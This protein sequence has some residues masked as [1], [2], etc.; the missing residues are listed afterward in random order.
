M[1][2]FVHKHKLFAQAILGLIILTFAFFGVESYFRSSD[3]SSPVASVG[4]QTITQQEFNIALRER[5]E[6]L[7]NMGG[8]KVDPALLDNAEMRFAVAEALVNQKLLLQQASRS[9]LVATDQQLQALLGQAPAFQESGTFSR[10]LYEQFL[11]VRNKTEVEFESD[12]RRDL[13]L[14]Q[15]SD[16]YG[17]SNF[18]P[19]TVVQRL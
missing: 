14:R 10:P 13:V 4:G 2:D 15:V 17:E 18:L 5:Q 19:R 3:A 8:G 9:R 12:L 1:F 6:M 11:K 16:P 7:Q